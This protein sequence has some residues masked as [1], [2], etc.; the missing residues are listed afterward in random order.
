[1]HSLVALLPMKGH[2]ERVPH[3]NIR[4]MCGKPLFFYIAQTLQDCR[5]IKSIIVNTDS[6][7]IAEMAQSHFPKVIIHWRPEE[8]RGDLVS[9][10][11]I[12]ADD[13][14]RC[15]GEHFLQTHSTNPLLKTATLEKG[16][17][18]YFQHLDTYDSLFAV[19]RLQ[20][21]LY[22]ASGEP[23]NHNPAELK[24]TQDLPPLFEENS[25]FYLFSRKSF[26]ASGNRRIG[27]HPQMFPID[28]LESIDIDNPQDFVLAETLMQAL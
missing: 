21:R 28:K 26:V 10:N 8:L 4:P 27:L 7:H 16:I 11:A 20:T 15:E 6:E 13:M 12:I 5:Y 9:M 14:A 24:R 17:E 1:M 25:C 18:A 19:T 3:K 23:V 2:S 22:W